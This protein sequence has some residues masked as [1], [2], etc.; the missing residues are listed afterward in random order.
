MHFD[1][2]SHFKRNVYGTDIILKTS[3][4]YVKENSMVILLS[5]NL[6]IFVSGKWSVTKDHLDDQYFYL[7]FS[8]LW[9]TLFDC[10]TR[11]ILRELS[12]IITKQ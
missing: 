6:F 7:L 1:F 12:K 8:H 2:K 3:Q 5:C 9:F 10:S 4:I 11:E